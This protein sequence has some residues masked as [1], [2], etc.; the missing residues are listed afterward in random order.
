MSYCQKKKKR[1]L[2]HSHHIYCVLFYIQCKHS[3]S[4]KKK[5]NKKNQHSLHIHDNV[6][7]FQTSQCL[8]GIVHTSLYPLPFCFQEKFKNDIL[9]SD[10]IPNTLCFLVIVSNCINKASSDAVAINI[11]IFL[12]LRLFS[13]K[14]T[15]FDCMDN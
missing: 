14:R 4:F 8:D 15:S 5:Q 1:C 7:L 13:I 11:S 3:F 9:S 10:F 2:M 6:S 12:S